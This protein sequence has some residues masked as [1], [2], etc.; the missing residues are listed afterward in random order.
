M[1]MQQNYVT[2]TLCRPIYVGLGGR[3]GRRPYLPHKAVVVVGLDFARV[4]DFTGER[5][6]P[7]R[8][9]DHRVAS[10]EHSVVD[11]AAERLLAQL[12][13]STVPRHTQA[14]TGLAARGRIAAPDLHSTT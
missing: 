10:A 6:V 7:C 8:A 5:A 9:R 1:H 3:A 2:V 14:A 4:D 13:T 11:G 12:Q